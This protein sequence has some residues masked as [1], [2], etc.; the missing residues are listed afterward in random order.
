MDNP[1]RP[2]EK[3]KSFKYLCNVNCVYKGRYYRTGDVITLPE[4]KEVPHFKLAED[5]KK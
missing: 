3:P 5:E 1:L 4:K 2:E